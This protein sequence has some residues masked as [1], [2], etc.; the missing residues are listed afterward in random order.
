[1]PLGPGNYRVSKEY[2]KMS[3]ACC[4]GTAHMYNEVKRR[5]GQVTGLDTRKLW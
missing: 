5:T 3:S 1:V 4:C 2:F